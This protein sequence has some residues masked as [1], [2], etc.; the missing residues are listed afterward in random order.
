MEF[1]LTVDGRDYLVIMER[2]TEGLQVEI[3]GQD[4]SVDA[5]FIDPNTV[6][7]FLGERAMTVHLAF[8]GERI[9]ASTD[10]EKFEIDRSQS[11]SLAGQ[12]RGRGGPLEA[13]TVISTPM[14]G[15]IVKVQVKEGE[16]VEP[17]QNLF[18]V[19]SMKMEN[20]IKSSI[21]AKVEKVHFGD[22]DP[23]EANAPIVE[24]SLLTEEPGV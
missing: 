7:L 17:G 14:P 9:Y 10:G 2:G 21:K 4:E 3:D 23:V 13:E 12:L 22:G 1:E 16:I 18:I 15:Q 19:E 5:A 24:L 8:E 11:A 6:S 20:Q